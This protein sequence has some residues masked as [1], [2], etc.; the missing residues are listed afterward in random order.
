[1]K[2]E[3]LTGSVSSVNSENFN[4]GPQLAPQ[5]LIQGKIAGVNIS[6]NSGKPGGAN[7]VRIRGGT[8]ITASNDPLYVI[9]G[10]PISTSA[11]VSS[12]NIRTG[13]ISIHQQLGLAVDDKGYDTDWQ[14]EVSRTA[15]QHN[16]YLSMTGGSEQTRIR[17]SVG[18]GQQEG[19]LLSSKLDH[20]NARVWVAWNQ[21]FQVIGG[22]N[23]VLE[24][25]EASPNAGNLTALIA[26]TRALRAYGYFF[27]MDYWG[28]V[29]IVTTARIDPNNLPTNSS[30]EDVFKF[31]ETEML[32]AVH[33]I[34]AAIR[35]ARAHAAQYNID[36]ERIAISGCSAGGQFAALVGM[37]NGVDKFEGYQ[38]NSGYSSAV[39][40]VLDI[41]GV[42]DYM[43][44]FLQKVF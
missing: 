42:V 44:G 5:Q 24:N 26:E 8:S 28:N 38:G 13:S 19:V 4:V 40:A 25:L 33:N 34:K 31:I 35:W 2:R 30:R 9:D 6:K 32:A 12:A 18:Y 39:Q 22:A 29:P 36:P 17:A 11:G 7:S 20:A 1:M 15:F 14:D 16:H 3:D 41:D 23:A 10:V 43:T 37:T 27:A 21:I